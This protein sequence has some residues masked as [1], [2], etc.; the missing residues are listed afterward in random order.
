MLTEPG[1]IEEYL[2]QRQDALVDDKS[3]DDDSDNWSTDGTVSGRIVSKHIPKKPT[4]CKPDDEQPST[5]IT[6]ESKAIHEPPRQLTMLTEPGTIEEYMRQRQDALVDD[7]S[8]DDDSDNWSTDGTG[9][10]QILSKRI[11][12]KSSVCEH[13][14]EHR[15]KEQ[16][17]KEVEQQKAQLIASFEQQN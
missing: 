16:L 11:P 14:N 17:R 9:T 7:K 13:E 6:G 12:K 4:V 15:K 1:T 10:G 2:R 8:D 5:H 3:D